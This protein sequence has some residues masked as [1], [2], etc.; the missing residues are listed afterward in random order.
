MSLN[1]LRI[2]FI[3]ANFLRTAEV[4]EPLSNR[5]KGS[6]QRRIRLLGFQAQELEEFVDDQVNHG[7]IERSGDTL[8]AHLNARGDA[9][10]LV[11]ICRMMMTAGRGPSLSFGCGEPET[12]SSCSSNQNSSRPIRHP[13][14]IPESLKCSLNLFICNRKSESVSSYLKHKLEQTQMWRR[15]QECLE[16]RRKKACIGPL[17]RTQGSLNN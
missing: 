4:L 3:D 11:E 10:R 14:T 6:K 16:Q 9:A 17:C 7:K 12:K 1:T 2:F 15:K 8:S 5:R 13:A